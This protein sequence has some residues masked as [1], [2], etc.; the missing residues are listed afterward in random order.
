M[1]KATSSMMRAYS[2]LMGR[3]HTAEDNAKAASSNADF[4]KENYNDARELIA[5]LRAELDQA[6]TERAANYLESIGRLEEPEEE[7]RRAWAQRHGN[8]SGF[9]PYAGKE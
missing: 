3:L 7:H 1:T 6:R 4:W 2:E 5:A 9:D 8:D